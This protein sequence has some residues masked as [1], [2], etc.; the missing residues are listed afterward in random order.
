MTFPWLICMDTYRPY[1]CLNTSALAAWCCCYWPCKWSLNRD[2]IASGPS[3]A[4]CFA[5]CWRFDRWPLPQPRRRSRFSHATWYIHILVLENILIEFQTKLT[6]GYLLLVRVDF[7]ENCTTITWVFI[8]LPSEPWWW[9]S[10]IS[11]TNQCKSRSLSDRFSHIHQN[12]TRVAQD[13][14]RIWG[15]WN[16]KPKHFNHITS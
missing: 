6:N 3:D 11:F 4:T 16:W 5:L 15:N 12:S 1:W 14:W 9:I 8:T 2:P 10:S 13:H 7:V